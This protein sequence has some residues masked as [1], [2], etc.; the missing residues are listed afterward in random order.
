[1]FY[2]SLYR[3]G[4]VFLFVYYIFGFIVWIIINNIDL[5]IRNIDIN[6]VFLW[7]LFGVCK[8]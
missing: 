1:M 7:Y 5:L 2:L 3:E 4:V 6:V 8:D